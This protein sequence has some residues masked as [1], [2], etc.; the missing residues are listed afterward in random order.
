MAVAL[1]CEQAVPLFITYNSVKQSEAM[2]D[3]LRPLLEARLPTFSQNGVNEV[4][5]G[6]LLGMSQSDFRVEGKFAAEAIANIIK[7]A[8]PRSQQKAYEE[9][10]SLAVNLRT[11]LLIGWNPP[12]AV[13]SAVD[14]FFQH[15]PHD[16]R[17]STPPVK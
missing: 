6:V 15:H 11:A 12:L 8:T 17:K 4:K 7:G 9:P 1:L 16:V 14:E 2:G 5:S 13:L 3:I 10:L